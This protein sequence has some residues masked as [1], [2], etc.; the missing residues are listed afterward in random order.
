MIS[1]DPNSILHMH[2]CYCAT[3][4]FLPLP[5]PPLTPFP[6]LP[7]FLPCQFDPDLVMVSCGLDAAKGDPLGNCSITPS[8]YA[9][10]THL[11]M[12][13]AGGRIVVVLEVQAGRKGSIKLGD[14]GRGV[15]LS[16]DPRPPGPNLL[17]EQNMCSRCLA[18][19]TWCPSTDWLLWHGFVGSLYAVCMHLPRTQL[20][21]AAQF[22]LPCQT[23][24]H[25]VRTAVCEGELYWKHTWRPCT[26]VPCDTVFAA[27]A[28]DDVQY[29]EVLERI[30]T[31]AL[32]LTG[33]LQPHLHLQLHGCHCWSVAGGPP[34]SPGRS[35]QAVPEC[36]CLPPRCNLRTPSALERAGAPRSGTDDATH[37]AAP[38]CCCGAS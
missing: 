1:L 21:C 16:K 5:S 26:A 30:Y 18:V 36:P 15:I 22:P 23:A 7:L 8:G 20:C 38:P 6:S 9:H 10:M 4:S 28:D 19:F 29:T 37:P 31:F 13:L 27:C 25:T 34:P 3:T 17:H 14:G 33:R 35:T 12:G 24:L 2:Q 11:L 32:P